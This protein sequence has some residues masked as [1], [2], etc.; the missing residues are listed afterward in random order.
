MY[1]WTQSKNWNV[2]INHGHTFLYII[3]LQIDYYILAIGMCT[4]FLL[5][6]DKIR[7][8]ENY[9]VMQ[10]SDFWYCLIEILFNIENLNKV[11]FSMS[12]I[13]FAVF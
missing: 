13:L 3:T 8:Q 11:I 6:W 12:T 4:A 2:Y 7:K 1:K 10:R 5:K 9:Y